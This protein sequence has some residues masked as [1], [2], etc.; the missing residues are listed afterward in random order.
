[1]ELCRRFD[2]RP[3][4]EAK[5][6]ALTNVSFGI[7]FAVAFRVANLQLFRTFVQELSLQLRALQ[8]LLQLLPRATDAIRQPRSN[9]SDSSCGMV[10]ILTLPIFNPC[11]RTCAPMWALIRN[12]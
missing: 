2:M 10:V 8:F 7:G 1:M 5:K 6:K 9:G 12:Q 4:W 3:R 11:A